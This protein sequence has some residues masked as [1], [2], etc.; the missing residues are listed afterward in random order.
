[1][2]NETAR[3]AAGTRIRDI[4]PTSKQLPTSRELRSYQA[5][6]TVRQVAIILCICPATVRRYTASRKLP[7]VRLG[8]R[9]RFDP[10][11]VADFLEGRF[12]AT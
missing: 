6:L 9:L 7:H 1:M 8:N 5:L 2:S 12:P 3:K 4:E 10:A 11:V